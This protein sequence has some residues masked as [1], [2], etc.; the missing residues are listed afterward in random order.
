MSLAGIQNN[1]L[2]TGL[3]RYDAGNLDTHLCEVVLSRSLEAAAELSV[4]L[5]PPGGRLPPLF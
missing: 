1:S 5:L 4:F 2:D 3:R